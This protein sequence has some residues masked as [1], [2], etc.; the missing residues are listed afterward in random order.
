MSCSKQLSTTDR[1]GLDFYKIFHPQSCKC[2]FFSIN[3]MR[4]F[5]KILNMRGPRTEPWGIT[6]KISIHLLI[7]DSTFTRCFRFE[8]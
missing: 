5:I 8:K 1:L 6:V 3:I 7:A 2:Q 4:W